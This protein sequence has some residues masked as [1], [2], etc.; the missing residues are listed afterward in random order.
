MGNAAAVKLA[1]NGYNVF[2]LD[3]HEPE[4][5]DRMTYIKTD[6][7]DSGS[8]ERAAEEISVKAGQIAGII[9]LAGIYDLNSLIE[10]PEED[11]RKIFDI[12]LF[13]V[14]R[15][16]RIFHPLLADKGRIIITSSELAPLSPLPFTGIYGITKSAVEKYALSLRMELQLIG[17]D[18]IILRPGA[19]DTGLLDVSTKRLDDFCQST[20]LYKFGSEKFR[21][22][23]N[24]IEAGKIPP[25]KIAD[26]ILKALEVKKPRIIYSANRNP[27]LMIMN[28]LP[29]RIQNIIIK[30]IL[31]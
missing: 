25:E 21:S 30:M 1:D 19:V 17:Q 29:L 5:A 10:M 23:V 27:L 16:N 18:V 9:H 3:I 7:T 8:V 26:I 24:K 22:V 13:S 15:V 28:S 20:S 12:N 4:N 11:F 2:A 14:Y 6:L 31:S